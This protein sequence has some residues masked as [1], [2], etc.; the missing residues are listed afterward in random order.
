VGS[1]A[2]GLGEIC[3]APVF[4]LELDMTGVDLG[5]S[6]RIVLTAKGYKVANYPD[7]TI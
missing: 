5:G 2:N 3:R 6:T 7:A 4:G 1:L